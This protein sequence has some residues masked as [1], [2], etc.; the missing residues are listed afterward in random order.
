[1]GLPCG[2]ATESSRKPLW[3]LDLAEQGERVSTAPLATLQHDL[4]G[5]PGRN[6]KLIGEEKNN[7][8]KWEVGEHGDPQSEKSEFKS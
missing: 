3:G 4:T 2:Y 6:R 1:M 5:G 7:T 8:L